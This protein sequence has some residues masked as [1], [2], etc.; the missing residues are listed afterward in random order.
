MKTK[1]QWN[2]IFKK[3]LKT[4]KEIWHINKC[5]VD[6]NNIKKFKEM[7]FILKKVFMLNIT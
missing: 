1:I 2:Q 7:K 6:K 4:I 3:I 5:N